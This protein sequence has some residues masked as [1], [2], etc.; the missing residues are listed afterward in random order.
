MDESESVKEYSERLIN[1]A[2]K[3]R[4]LGSE[5]KDERLMQKILVSLLE[6][7]EATIASLENTKDLSNIK[8]A[9]LLSALQ[10][11]EQRRMMRCKGP[12]EGAL[13]AKLKINAGEK[14]KKWYNQKGNAEDSKAQARERSC[15]GADQKDKGKH[16]AVEGT[17]NVVIKSNSGARVISDVLYVPEIDQNLLSVSQL[18]NKGY[19]VIFEGKCCMITNLRGEELFKV[20]MRRKF[21]SLDPLEKKHLAMK[22]EEITSELWHKRLGH[23]NYKG[24]ISMQRLRLAEGLLAM[25]E[26]ESPCT[27]CLLGKQSRL[28]F[29]SS[30]WRATE[31]LQLVHTDVC[32]PTSEASLSGSKYFLIFVDDMTRMSWIYFLKAKTKQI[33]LYSCSTDFQLK[34]VEGKTPYEAWNGVNPVVKN[35]RVFGCL[36]YSHVPQTKRSK[37]DEKS[38]PGIFV[39]YSLQSK[40]YRVFHPQTDRVIVSRD[41]V[42]MEKKG[43]AGK[44]KIK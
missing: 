43:G 34:V 6:K 3:I 5:M 13:Q 25:K 10:A 22:G 26:K 12:L 17:G 29:K 14:G 40:D 31:K 7:F 36:C 33:L 11:Q 4:V 28:P 16:N 1:I 23:Y 42:F 8:L 44:T 38:E 19:K 2:N 18:L 30:S 27:A 37:L 20:P 32:G 21:F 9:E 35:L 39:G 41:V 24:L 15:S